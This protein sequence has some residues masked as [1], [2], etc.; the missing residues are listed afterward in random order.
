[1]IGAFPVGAFPVMGGVP[2]TSPA[3]STPGGL[4]GTFAMYPLFNSTMTMAALLSGSTDMTPLLSG[5][6][7]VDS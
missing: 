7:Q 4:L 6:L 3:T 2:N 1:M 5:T